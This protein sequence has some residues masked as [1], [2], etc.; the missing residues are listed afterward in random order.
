MAPN[1]CFERA[2]QEYR[3]RS[4][5]P[6]E[7]ADLPTDVQDDITKRAHQIQAA[8]NRLNELPRAA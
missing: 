6:D 2:L 3:E 1:E 7:Y 4:W 5:C 8:D